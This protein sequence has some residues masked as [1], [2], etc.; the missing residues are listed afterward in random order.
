MLRPAKLVRRLA[1]CVLIS[2]SL[3]ALLGHASPAVSIAILAEKEVIEIDARGQ[4][5]VRRVIA[6]N[7]EPGEVI[8]Y[9][10]SYQNDGQSSARDIVLDN[11]VPEGTRLVDDSA[12]GEQAEIQLPAAEAE[13]GQAQVVRWLISEIPAGTDG[14]VGF[15]VVVL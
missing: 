2:F 5:V 4:E 14:A 10:I 6:E 7:A 8:F 15:S 9:T 13:A 11:P 1:Q 3:L 12:W